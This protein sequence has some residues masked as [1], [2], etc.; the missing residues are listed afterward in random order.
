MRKFPFTSSPAPPQ[1]SQDTHHSFMH[2]LV[3]KPSQ[4]S[5]FWPNEK[6]GWYHVMPLT[7]APPWSCVDEDGMA[8][9]VDAIGRGS[10]W[11]A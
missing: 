8:S 1:K 6:F 4:K 11:R 3:I 7:A 5:S 9:V 10:G 2:L